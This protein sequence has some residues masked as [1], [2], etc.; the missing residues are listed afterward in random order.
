MSDTHGDT[1]GLS[2]VVPVYNGA[3]TVGPLVQAI[4]ALNVADGHE[5]VLVVDG[6][7]DDSLAV[8]RALADRSSL[9]ITV[10]ELARNFGEHNA[11]TAGLAFARGAWIITMDD[12]LQ[13]P[14]AE[15]IR[16]YDHARSSGLDVVYTRYATKQH[17]WWRNV[18]SRF[19]NALADRVLP[20]PRGLYL[21]SFRCLNAFAAR[22]VVAYA[23]PY[24]YVDGLL[25]QA[26]QRVGS[27]EVLHLPRAA[28]RSNYTP[29]RLM[30]LF[31]AMALG[32][33]IMP[34]RLATLVGLAM[35]GVGLV[36]VV[37]VVA[38][39]LLYRPPAGWASLMA[40]LLVLAGVQLVLLGI[41]GEYLGRLFLTVNGRPQYV[42]RDVVRGGTAGRRHADDE[43]D[44]VG[45]VTPSPST[46]P[47][48]RSAA[49]RSPAPPPPP[50][51]A[52]TAA[53]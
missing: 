40:A 52:G 10:V 16:L 13:N 53:G 34:L 14:P 23:G 33:S 45:R 22:Q 43:T 12:D 46:A 18:G 8:C 19:T 36:A 5:I 30:R 27:L 29:R 35:S 1:I 3:R 26:T 48:A 38:E 9:P 42:V 6:S 39:G 15:V 20:K 4:A 7:P 41:I 17:A 11:V 37:F 24:P 32:F 2:I 51:A 49:P 25:M 21:S 47:P 44:A 28:G 50:P 31:L